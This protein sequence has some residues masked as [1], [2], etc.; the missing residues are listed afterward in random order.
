MLPTGRQPGRLVDVDYFVGEP[1]RGKD[2][3]EELK[4]AGSVSDF[5]FKFPCRT[6]CGV[7]TRMK[8]PRREFIDE[9]SC[10]VAELPNQ[11]DRAIVFQRHHRGRSGMAHNF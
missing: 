5:F 7:F 1:W 3:G 9:S 11:D 10:R 6:G 2:A 4:L 8:F